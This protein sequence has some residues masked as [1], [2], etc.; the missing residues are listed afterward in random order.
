[1]SRAT[2]GIG[3]FLGGLLLGVAAA[4]AYDKPVEPEWARSI[5]SRIRI[6]CVAKAGQIKLE[7]IGTGSWEPDASG[8][9]RPAAYYLVW[10]I[11]P[12]VRDVQGHI[13]LAAPTPQHKNYALE[14]YHAYAC[15][16][17]ELIQTDLR[18]IVELEEPHLVVLNIPI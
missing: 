13:E 16:L 15:P 6:G 5:M 2:L 12:G 10:S 7:F 18:Y 11:G 9:S 8:I 1:M 4:R 3:A 14:F 17:R